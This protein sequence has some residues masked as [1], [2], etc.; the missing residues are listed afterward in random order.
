MNDDKS[1]Q[2]TPV[3]IDKRREYDS[4]TIISQKRG[5]KYYIIA[6]TKEGKILS[7]REKT[8]KF[9]LERAKFKWKKDYSLDDGVVGYPLT[10]VVEYTI[11]VEKDK[12]VKGIRKG[13]YQF[14][15]T[16]FLKDRS[17]ITARSFQYSKET[18]IEVLRAE[19]YDNFY[20]RVNNHISGQYDADESAVAKY[21][22]SIK[23]EVIQYR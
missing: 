22:L 1:K 7:S 16:G 23:E 13:L 15:V 4:A 20:A 21:I 14:A 2:S 19:A 9:T 11:D 18:N 5:K 8:H 12:P 6:K 10:N 3:K 17:K